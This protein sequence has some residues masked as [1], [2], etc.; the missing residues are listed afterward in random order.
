MQSDW[1]GKSY[2]A[3]VDFKVENTEDVI[4]VYT[5]RPDTLHGATFMVL[6]PEH[7][8]ALGLATS[9]QKA[10]VEEYIQMAANKSSVDRL[11][12][13]EKQVYL[14]VVMQLTHLM[15]Q[16]FQSGFQIMY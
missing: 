10:A 1:I 11:Q 5:T 9:E 6:A 14:Q 3:E 4:T 13:K 8:K 15:E 12:G 16:R 7:E 2:G